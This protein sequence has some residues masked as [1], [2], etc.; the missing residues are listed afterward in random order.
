[1]TTTAITPNNYNAPQGISLEIGFLLLMVA[2]GGVLNPLF[3][4]LHLSPMHC[5]V[6]AA[7]GL[8]AVWAG[9]SQNRSRM[10]LVEVALGAFFLLN[11]IAG[12]LFS[13]PGTLLRVAPGFLELSTL[14]H[15]LHL[16][17]AGFFLSEAA[18]W[19][20]QGQL[21]P[22]IARHSWGLLRRVLVIGFLLSFIM[23]VVAQI[24]EGFAL[25]G[26]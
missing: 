12:F 16:A 2:F 5:F 11:A 1:M 22:W 25:Y 7:S 23:T 24:E 9:L 10:F 13:S 20:F 3:I 26:R 8:I 4:G 14:D 18:I 17:L 19:K 21:K 15:I 6:L